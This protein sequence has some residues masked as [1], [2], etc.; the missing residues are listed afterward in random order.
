MLPDGPDLRFQAAKTSK[1]DALESQMARIR[2]IVGQLAA[3][4]RELFALGLPI[5]GA[6]I[7][8][9]AE[10]IGRDVSDKLHAAGQLWCDEL[11]SEP[12]PSSAMQPGFDADG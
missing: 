5:A 2:A 11:E 8:A 6:R 7:A 1:A 10:Q 9:V 4:Q 3:L 12:G